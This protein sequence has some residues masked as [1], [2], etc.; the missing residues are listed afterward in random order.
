MRIDCPHCGA[1]AVIRTSMEMAATV[2]EA[3]VQCPNVECAHTWVVHISAVRT[4]APSMTPKA[5]VYIPLSPRSPAAQAPASDQMSLP[6]DDINP[7]AMA[8]NSS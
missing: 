6:M 2:R 5:G 3:R 7:R 4:I 8:I 1:T